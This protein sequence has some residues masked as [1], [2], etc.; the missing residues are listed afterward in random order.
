MAG[1]YKLDPPPP[2]HKR[3]EKEEA[4]KKA[5]PGSIKLSSAYIY[6]VLACPFGR[7]E[8]KDVRTLTYRGLRAICEG[9]R[10]RHSRLSNTY[11]CT[12]SACHNYNYSG[13]RGKEK[14]KLYS[15]RGTVNCQS[16]YFS[17]VPQS[18]F[19]YCWLFIHLL[20]MD[21]TKFHFLIAAAL[22]FSPPPPH[23]SNI[24]QQ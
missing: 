13:K 22:G 12:M 10:G 3:K 17:Q 4:K 7:Y 19:T 2:M 23:P 9:V 8:V 21:G 1:S 11:P 15:I 18:P 16:K 5:C 14:S 24:R 20:D 6:V